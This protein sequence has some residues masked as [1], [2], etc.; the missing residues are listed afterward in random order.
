[1]AFG[2]GPF[3]TLRRIILP[4]A[5]RAILPAMANQVIS[6]IKGTS[7]ASVIFVNELTFRSQ[8]I[9]GQNFKF[10]TVFAAAG[11]IYLVMTSAVAGLQRYLE[12]HFNPEIV[13]LKVATVLPN[14]GAE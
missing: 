9:V 12:R 8:Q 14:G 4:Q 11:L 7:I 13:L 6:L 5:M 2:M 1:A 3:L 10:F